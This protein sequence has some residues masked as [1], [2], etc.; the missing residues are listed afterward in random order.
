MNATR[1]KSLGHLRVR[2]VRDDKGDMMQVADAL[3]IRCGIGV[4][5]FVGKNCDQSS[6]ARIKIQMIL[7]GHIQVR[8][9]KNKGH[10]QD[11]FPKIK[12]GLPVGADQRNV[13]DTL[14]LDFLHKYSLLRSC[15]R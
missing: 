3:R 6:V 7:G 4:T 12:R 5:I 9:L 10:A 14:G 13:M 15:S 1:I 2:G 8:L 11:A